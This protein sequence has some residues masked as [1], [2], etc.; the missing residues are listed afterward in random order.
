MKKAIIGLI[1]IVSASLAG[2]YFGNP[3][4]EVIEKD[5]GSTVVGNDY[6]YASSTEAGAVLLKTGPTS[7]GSVVIIEDT[8]QV[9]TITD[10]TS[11]TDALGVVVGVFEASVPHGTYTFDVQLN[12]GLV[13]EPAAS[14]AGTYITTYR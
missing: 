12:R 10:A 7:L 1:L 9:F 4:E 14:F 2:F 6:R 11:T 13:I 8:A 3:I 5:L